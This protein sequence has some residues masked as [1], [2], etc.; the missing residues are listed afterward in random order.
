MKAKLPSQQEGTLCKSCHQSF[1][2]L[3]SKIHKAHVVI[4]R[5]CKHCK[6]V[7][8][9][10]PGHASDTHAFVGTPVGVDDRTEIITRTEP[11]SMRI[12]TPEVEKTAETVKAAY[13]D[14]H[15]QEKKID[16][17]QKTQKRPFKVLVKDTPEHEPI[18]F[19]VSKRKKRNTQMNLKPLFSWIKK[20]K[21]PLGNMKY[22]LTL[23][24]LC[25]T[26]YY[27]KQY[28]DFMKSQKQ[29]K[30][31]LILPSEK[32]SAHREGG[33]VDDVLIEANSLSQMETHLEEKIKLPIQDDALHLPDLKEISSGF[34]IRLD[35]FTHQLAF[36]G[37]LD[38]S[39]NYGEK[40][41]AVM[42]GKVIHAGWKGSYG[43][44]VIIKHADGYESRYA[45]LSK[46][47]VNKGERIK[48]GQWIG[49]VGSSGRSTGPHLHLEL[50]KNGKK[51]NPLVARL[52]K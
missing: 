12:K 15:R 1:D 38:F 43:R 44:T 40:V 51:I 42:E 49:K 47:L 14:S 28:L 50:L 10:K 19:S 24:L 30:A 25:S 7:L 27:G 2:A 26:V 3:I 48:K 9:I 45:H 5:P 41:H 39:Q 46:L 21:F 16:P 52:K 4:K 34:G 35:P 23:V 8:V 11:V 22:I 37:G 6:T 33:P 17:E 36:H 20:I 13:Y 31:P 29:T 18:K 32:T